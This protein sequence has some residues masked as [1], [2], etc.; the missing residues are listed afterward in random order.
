MSTGETPMLEECT[1]KLDRKTQGHQ[2]EHH[3]FNFCVATK[4]TNRDKRVTYEIFELNNTFRKDVK[5][6]D[7]IEFTFLCYIVQMK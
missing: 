3:K 2:K 6:I 4:T 7:Q 1:L 5:E